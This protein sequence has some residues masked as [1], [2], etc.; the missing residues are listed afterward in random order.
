MIVIPPH[1]A[2]FVDRIAKGDLREWFY[3]P[4]PVFQR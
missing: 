4:P 3:P 2:R 1:L